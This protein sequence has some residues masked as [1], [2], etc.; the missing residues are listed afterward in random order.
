MRVKLGAGFENHVFHSDLRGQPVFAMAEA[1]RD[2]RVHL[3][4]RRPGGLREN[5]SPASEPSRN[6][7][8]LSSSIE[9]RHVMKP[10]KERLEKIEV[11][12]PVHIPT[13]DRQSIAETVFVKVPAWRDP[14]DGEIYFDEEAQ[15]IL[16]RTKARYMGL[17]SPGHIKKL[18]NSE[19]RTPNPIGERRTA[20]GERQ[21]IYWLILTSGLPD[22]K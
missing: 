10:L 17:L 3:S 5:L 15:L 8:F 1:G 18:P 16:D 12:E 22:R 7:L 21:T 6:N 2:L 11:E 19:L 14:A 4:A 20:N 9:R 13:L